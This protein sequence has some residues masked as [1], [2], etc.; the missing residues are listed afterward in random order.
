MSEKVEEDL[1]TKLDTIND[2]IKQLKQEKTDKQLNIQQK[3]A[4]LDHGI[5]VIE[6][7]LKNVEAAMGE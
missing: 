4:K 7:S 3:Q 1:Q 2:S 6:K 5:K